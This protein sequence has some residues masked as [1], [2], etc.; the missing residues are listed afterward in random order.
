VATSTFLRQVQFSPDGGSLLYKASGS[1]SG[2]AVHV[3]DATTGRLRHKV[4]VPQGV[5][6]ISFGGGGAQLF[7]AVG[8]T[9][10][11]WRA[12]RPA[13]F[14]VRVVPGFSTYA[15]SLS[16]DG[17]RLAVCLG[18]QTRGAKDYKR[19]KIRVFD[20]TTRK[21]LL[22]ADNPA[23]PV[24]KLL[25]SADGKRLVAH[26]SSVARAE[27]PPDEL[28]VWDVDRKEKIGS[29]PLTA[30]PA[31]GAKEAAGSY[32][33]HA[34]SANGRLAALSCRTGVS[35]EPVLKIWEVPAGEER[36]ELAFKVA[37]S[38]SMNVN[39]Q[40]SPDGRPL[41]F[42]TVPNPR[43]GGRAMHV[44]D[45][46][47]GKERWSVPGLGVRPLAQMAAVS[48]GVSTDGKLLAQWEATN[49]LS[50]L[51]GKSTDIVLRDLA[52]KEKRRLMGHTVVPVTSIEFSPDGQRLASLGVPVSYKPSRSGRWEIKVWD[53]HNG[54][55][56]LTLTAEEPLVSINHG[57]V[58]TI[59]GTLRFSADGH[60]LLLVSR[61]G[62]GLVLRA[63]DATPRPAQGK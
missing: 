2:H 49:P 34:I 41:L 6:D 28:V 21:G 24:S 44:L 55:E 58:F 51:H 7:V 36:G 54:H 62:E 23:G 45:L 9:V 32:D 63:W 27:G 12:V 19:I 39:V 20:T 50:L 53:L 18:P 13:P 30:A 10:Q 3:W 43:S 22:A 8:T 47:T 29:C 33:L 52:G 46:E 25:L 26:L 14:R 35:E 60:R 1:I 15:W 31:A 16:A 38:P 42:V 11:V 17:G 61:A 59:D 40:F 56:V 5:S 4:L 57:F 48:Y 37:R